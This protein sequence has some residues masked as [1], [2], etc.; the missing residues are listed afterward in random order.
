MNSGTLFGTRPPHVYAKTEGQHETLDPPPDIVI[1]ASTGP[2]F[3]KTVTK[4]VMKQT[5]L[6]LKTGNICTQPVEF[7]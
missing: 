2:R 4:G 3:T 7:S 1:I 6:C 5:L